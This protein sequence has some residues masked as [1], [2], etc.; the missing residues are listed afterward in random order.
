[1]RNLGLDLLRILAVF[2][3]LG[4]HFHLSE[5]SPRILQIWQTGGWIG[6]DIFFVLSGFLV[7]GLLFREHQKT[8]DVDIKRFLIR[9]ALKIYPAFWLMI[10]VSVL[11]FLK[12]GQMIEFKSLFSEFLFLQNYI[13]G[14]W[15][16]TWSLAVEEHFYL[17]LSLLTYLLVRNSKKEAFSRIPLIYFCIFIFC[18]FFRVVTYFIV[19]DFSFK[20]YVFASHIRFDS[21]FF[22]V[23]LS[24][25]FHFKDMMSF[26]EKIP[27]FALVFIGFLFLSPA[28]L[29]QVEKY[30]WISV[31][32]VVL[33]YIGSG[34]LLIASVRIKESRNK[35][36]NFLGVLGGASYS[37]YLWHMPIND[38]GG[39]ILYKFGLNDGYGFY[40]VVAPFI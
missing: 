11:V 5:G 14:F 3:V 13:H 20:W 22:G 29:F 15:N 4:R 6:V 9:R 35:F 21:L 31:F 33:F 1:M 40:H 34:A 37:I 38:W 25:L 12:K 19:D 32:G 28:F 26:F 36:C 17:F 18:M 8:G 7:S 23:L 10:L 27:S 39:D 16:H 24:Y 2:L 30:K